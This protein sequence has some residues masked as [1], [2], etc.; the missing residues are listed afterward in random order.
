MKTRPIVGIAGLV[1]ALVVMIPV[2]FF[3]SRGAVGGNQFLLI[4]LAV[5][6]LV[7]WTIAYATLVDPLLRKAIGALFGLTIQWQGPGSSVAWTPLE[8]S[9]CLAGFV[10]GILG[11]IFIFLWLIPLVAGV[12]LI[13]YVSR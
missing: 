3:V 7:L 11:Y 1:V 5:L 2:L 9:G 12:A 4:G 13:W 8:K 10:V 6:A